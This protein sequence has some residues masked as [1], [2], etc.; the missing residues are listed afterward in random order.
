MSKSHSALIPLRASTTWILLGIAACLF[1][2]TTATAHAQ[3][4][5]PDEPKPIRQLQHTASDEDVI[6][7]VPADDIF[8]GMKL[9]KRDYNELLENVQKA[10]F[11][12]VSRENFGSEE[13]QAMQFPGDTILVPAQIYP[14]TTLP[15]FGSGKTGALSSVDTCSL[16]DVSHEN[17]KALGRLI[18]SLLADRPADLGA[19]T[20]NDPQSCM[21][22]Q[23]LYYLD[24]VAQLAPQ[25]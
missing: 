6:L 3:Q 25:S 1:C 22:T 15:N 4:Y 19:F 5:E 9:S 23:L 21:R 12:V 18:R 2:G 16:S 20:S 24:L 11:K 13:F 10:D 14:S 7:A 8:K 17:V